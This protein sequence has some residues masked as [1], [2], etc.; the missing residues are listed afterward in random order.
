VKY[1]G[2]GNEVDGAW[3]IGYKTPQEYARAYL[4]FA[5]V[6]RWVDPSIKLLASATSDW[7]Q[8]IVERTQLL[9]EQAHNYI[10]YIA[11]HWYVG[12]RSN[13]FASYMALS[14][15]IEDRLSCFEGLIRALHFQQKTLHPI[16]LAVDEWNVWYRTHPEGA[17]SLDRL[18]EIY[19]L[20]DAL[21]V[22]I[23][24][25]AFIRHAHSVKMANIAQLVNVIAPIFT[26]PDG[27]VLQTIFY[28]FEIYSRTCGD[29]ALDVF[30]KGETFST[31][32]RNGLRV[33]DVSASL[34]EE[35]RYLTVYAVNRS[36]SEGMETTISLDS[37]HFAGQVQAFVL[38]GPEIK[39]ENT[40]DNPFQVRTSEA[41]LTTEGESFHYTFEPH[42]VT[43]LVFAL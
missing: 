36:Q 4:E 18:E 7:K 17:G 25:N 37:G 3:Q 34:N 32:E 35:Q 23:Q 28:P 9:L 13:D 14:E 21:M 19:N 40:F 42:S 1:W 39:A 31:S 24:L 43:A 38:N 5:K 33:L 11:I 30:W 2:I 20:E 26:R 29:T 22:A 10:D 12:N 6:M 41:A 15:V 8:P 16:Y 27:L